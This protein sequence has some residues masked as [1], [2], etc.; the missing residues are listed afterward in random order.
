M[1][2]EAAHRTKMGEAASQGLWWGAGG[3][4]IVY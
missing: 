3:S 2:I 1:F 4:S